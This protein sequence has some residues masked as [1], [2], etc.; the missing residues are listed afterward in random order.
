[1]PVLK[2]K[3]TII[4]L[5]LFCQFFFQEITIAQKNVLIEFGWDYPDLKELSV[6]LP[7]MQRAPFNGICFSI[8]RDIF[9][10]FDIEKKPESYFLHKTCKSLKWGKFSHNYL[11]VRGFG[12]KGGFWF[13]DSLWEVVK[14]NATNIS[15]LL[16]NKNIKGILFDPEYYYED[17]L[18][19][20]WKYY[21]T[22]YPKKSFNEIKNQVMLRGMQ[23][24]SALQK[25]KPNIEIISIWFA[26]LMAQELKYT[27]LQDTRHTLLI[28]FLEGM[29]LA[30]NK[31]AKIIE[32]NEYGYWNTKASEF[33]QTK[34]NIHN[35]LEQNFESPISKA[36]V[37]D[38]QIAQPIFY[39]GLLALVPRF[40][41]GLMQS[42][43]W[44]WLTE[45]IKYSRL[46][47]DNITWLYN[48]R[49]NWWKEKVNDTLVKII[50][51]SN[52]FLNRLNM[53]QFKKN[54][55]YKGFFYSNNDLLPMLKKEEAF[56]FN[57]NQKQVEI[58]FPTVKPEKIQLFINNNVV[59][60]KAVLYNKIIIPFKKL[61]VKN[62]II[63]ATYKSGIEAVGV[64][65]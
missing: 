21:S 26:S 20:P 42:Q 28:P 45:N 63:L 12:K 56:T 24:M 11:I 34:Q 18:F 1:M 38:I 64:I 36:L 8:Q 52:L 54:A 10:S 53:G 13:N 29:L 39:D 17:S 7:N 58:F 57:I 51:A 19:N 15:T 23:F 55:I 25:H 16:N 50:Q 4:F 60:K 30:K 27:A 65:D 41:K 22:A 47:S 14:S 35:F 49:V 3:T 9:E 2:R 32:G 59:L 46:T 6:N 61:V 33:L 40:D 31:A 44:I 48:E 62:C 43:K 37:K 5:S